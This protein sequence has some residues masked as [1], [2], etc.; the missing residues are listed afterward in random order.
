MFTIRFIFDYRWKKEECFGIM[1]ASQMWTS[2]RFLI[3]LLLFFSSL[4]SYLTFDVHY[5]FIPINKISRVFRE[6]K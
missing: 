5:L 6:L 4:L 3:I 1:A 2:I